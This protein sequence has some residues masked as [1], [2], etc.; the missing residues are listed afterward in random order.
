MAD[1]RGG[2]FVTTGELEEKCLNVHT[3]KPFITLE[4]ATV[5]LDGHILFKNLNWE[6][7]N[8]QQLA[9]IGPNGSGKSA[10]MKVLAGI[11]PA[12]GGRIAYH[13]LDKGEVPHEH[14]TYVS[15]E[16]QREALGPEAYLQDRWNVGLSEE[17]PT[18]SDLLSESGVKHMNPFVVAHEK[19]DATF[20]GRRQ[21]IMRQLGLKPLL[22]RT[23]MQLSN[24]ERRKVTIARALLKNPCLLILDNPFEG[25]DVS[26]RATLKK[27]L[28][29]L[30][31]G[32]MRLII[33]GTGREEIPAGITHVLCINENHEVATGTRREMLE[34]LNI[35]GKENISKKGAL[36]NIK[37][38]TRPI[39]V[40][41]KNVNITYNQV[42]ILR[43]L[44]WTIHE[45]ERW[46]LFGPNGAGKTTLL[47]LI[48]GDNPQAYANDITLFGKKRGS[49]ESIW[50]IKRKI[51][52]VS[53][54]L[55]L[56]YPPD[57]TCFDVVCSGFFDTIGLYKR[58]TSSQQKTARS[59][60]KEL[61][62]GELEKIPFKD[63]SEG[64]E[65]LVL[66]A[67]ALVKNPA[68]LVLDEPCQGLDAGNRDRVLTAVDLACK[69]VTATMIYVTHRTDELP[70]GITNKLVLKKR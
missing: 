70:K 37:K 31:K 63:I 15:F 9:V 27:N 33:V 13:F 4:D 61:V 5:R 69:D 43:K 36:K 23:L 54:E 44:N 18:V 57:A 11:L 7:R 49:G 1:R 26:F 21:K 24:G 42:P 17:A 3:S 55:Q 68:L 34:K 40:Q 39:L 10:L 66:L 25:L 50:E 29:I 16:E 56:Y 20:S 52:W 19:A 28:E 38:K 22:K 41:M 59:W 30:M 53:P 65:R 32:D 60:L 62:L 51:G 14:I 67:R 35:E 12:V 8:D 64:E 48:L 2:S 47:S 46:A 45:G 58:C 6:I